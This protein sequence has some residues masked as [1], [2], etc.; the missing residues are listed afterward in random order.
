MMM[1]KD[2]KVLLLGLWLL[3]GL[4]L[5]SV[6]LGVQRI[7]QV[8]E[9][10]YACQARILAEG[11]VHPYLFSAP[12][13]LLGPMTWIAGAARSAV[14]VLVGCRLLFV[15]LLWVNALLLVK[16]A[17][18]RIRSRSGLGAL[19]LASTLAPMWDYGFEI[20][21]DVVLLTATLC[22]WN[23]V[24]AEQVADSLRFT[25][26]GTLTVLMQF[27]AFKGF[28]YAIPLLGIALILHYRKGGRRWVRVAAFILAGLAAG[29]LLGAAIHATAGTWRIFWG[30]QGGSAHDA[31]EVARF[32][33]DLLFSHLFH[34]APCLTCVG[35]AALCLPPLLPP[36]EGGGIASLVRRLVSGATFPEWAFAWVCV[37]VVLA[38]P[39]PFPYNL[40]HVVPALFLL[41]AAHRGSLRAALGGLPDPARALALGSLLLLWGLP[42]GVSTYRHLDMD[43][44]RQ[45]TVIRAAEAMTDPRLHRVFDG[46]GLVS[47]RDPI[48]EHWL[49]H[50]FTIRH[51]IDGSWPTVRSLLAQNATPVLL[52][53]YRTEW[54]PQADQDFIQAHY[55]ALAPDFLVLGKVGGPAPF[56][57]NALAEGR[58]LMGP[59]DGSGTLTV[60]GHLL[61]PGIHLLTRGEHRFETTSRSPVQLAWVGPR[62][63]GLPDLGPPPSHPLF[64]NWY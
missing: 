56:T 43:N 39:T 32:S 64:V 29:A 12:I 62:S 48:G 42:W 33:P 38:N 40:L 51:F 5:L 9:V 46:S 21:H 45:C 14:Q 54:L 8:D 1:E 55:V 18:L 57:W 3:A 35:L 53:N 41:L 11:K 59:R 26:A 37:V 17:G 58:Y 28:L 44:D 13:I 23:L 31:V 63:E 36:S 22:L 6:Y 25:L 52:P 16:G 19:L 61:E 47:T 60:D 34:E 50:T 27:L 49:L 30:N 7:F 10:Q 15:A 2:R 20:R 24:R 4:V